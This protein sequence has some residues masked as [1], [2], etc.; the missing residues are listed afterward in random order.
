MFQKESN[1]FSLPVRMDVIGFPC[2]PR[3]VCT[4]CPLLE[5]YLEKKGM[6]F[7]RGAASSGFQVQLTNGLEEKRHEYS[8]PLYRYIVDEYDREVAFITTSRSETL[9]TCYVCRSVDV[10]SLPDEKTERAAIT[11]H[12]KIVRYARSLGEAVEVLNTHLR[13]WACPYV[14]GDVTMEGLEDALQDDIIHA[15][16]SIEEAVDALKELRRPCWYIL[17]EGKK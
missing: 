8:K 14:W 4:G 10:R 7:L 11:F 13:G 9:P 15:R 5:Q 2:P 1:T 3:V 17:G 12:R 16:V 6:T